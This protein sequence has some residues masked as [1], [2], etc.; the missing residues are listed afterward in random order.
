MDL[1]YKTYGQGE[2][3]LI[4]LHGLLGSGRNWHTVCQ[5]LAERY[6][7]IVPDQRNHGLSPHSERHTLAGMVADVVA[8][9]DHL[10]SAP[11]YVLGHSMGGLVA[12]D[13]AFAHPERLHGLIVVDIA[14]RP[15]RA[16]V[17]FVLEAMAAIEISRF[18]NKSEVDEAL[19]KGIEDPLVR[20]F[21]LTNLQAEGDHLRWRI[22]LPALRAFLVES[23]AY[24]P[25]ADQRYDGPTLFIRGERSPYIRNEDLPL[26]RQ[27]FPTAE[28]ATVQNAGHWV[29]YEA[30]ETIIHL[31]DTFLRQTERS[32]LSP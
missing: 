29:H 14:P 5:A 11:S 7:L 12:M 1:F 19:A 24:K 8:L 3:H 9:Q 13:F 2:P 22:N 21:V 25:A 32:R 16:T 23:Q 30:P 26:I 10:Q 20:Q 18:Q 27:H 28:L 17:A 15:H 6:H 31:I 4:I